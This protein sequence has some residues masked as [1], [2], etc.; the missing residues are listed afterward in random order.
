MRTAHGTWQVPRNA[1]EAPTVMQWH[2][3]QR[4]WSGAPICPWCHRVGAEQAPSKQLQPHRP[5]LLGRPRLP[6]HNETGQ[7]PW[8]MEPGKA[9]QES[10]WAGQGGTASGR[11]MVSPP[12]NVP[13]SHLPRRQLLCHRPAC[14]PHGVTCM[15]PTHSPEPRAQSPEPYSEA[16][17]LW[18][19]L[20]AA[21]QTEVHWGVQP[22][23]TRL[24]SYGTEPCPS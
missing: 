8:G 24:P 14:G 23:L 18:E 7:R 21:H 3:R 6:R 20:K 4:I 22:H 5:K 11:G 19:Q 1:P 12:V 16:D 10:S 13:R 17:R 15:S 9:G 2:P